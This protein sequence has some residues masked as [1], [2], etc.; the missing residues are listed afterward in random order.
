MLARR[1]KTCLPLSPLCVLS[2]VPACRSGSSAGPTCI[3]RD[4][5][6]RQEVARPLVANAGS[7][8]RA[9]QLAGPGPGLL[10]LLEDGR[11]RADRHVVTVDML[12]QVSSAGRKIEDHLRGVQA[13]TVEVDDVHI[14]LQAR[15]KPTAVAEAEEIRRLA[16]L[17][18]H[19]IFE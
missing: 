11:A 4:R 8:G 14:P 19:D 2:C 7:A 18:L 5:P 10:A 12:N 9:N 15:L 6:T 1:R 16:G 3:W 17:C 13:Q